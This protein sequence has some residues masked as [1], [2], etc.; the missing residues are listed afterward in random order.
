MRTAFIDSSVLFAAAL[1]PT[2]A[3]HEVLREHIRGQVTLVLSSFV[4]HETQRNLTR[5][6]PPALPLLLD[7]VQALSLELV[8]PTPVEVANAATY[9]FPKDAP[10]VAAAKKA[11][12]DYLVS[13][14]RKHLVGVPAVAHGSGLTIVLPED[15]LAALRS[16]HR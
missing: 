14:D 12:V 5:K 9:T 15:L 11:N 4:L 2:G 3:S 13:L 16:H 8:N 7:L 1:S 10:I 6:P